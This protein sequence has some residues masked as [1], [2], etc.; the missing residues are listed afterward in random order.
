MKFPKK[1]TKNI[2]Q[3]GP[4]SFHVS[5]MHK[6]IRKTGTFETRKLAEQGKVLLEADAI[7]EYEEKLKNPDI[8]GEKSTSINRNMSTWSFEDT[9]KKACGL[10]QPQGYQGSSDFVTIEGRFKCI[11]SF[12]VAEEVESISDID[13]ELINKYV[14]HALKK[15]SNG[16]VN[17]KL[18]VIR[19]VLGIAKSYKEIKELP[20]F[21]PALIEGSVP[22]R[23]YTSQEINKLYDGFE[24]LIS[25]SQTDVIRERREKVYDCIRCLSDTVARVSEII[26]IDAPDIDFEDRTIRL[27]GKER[28]GTKNRTIRFV[29][30]TDEVYQILWERSQGGALKPF[31]G[32]SRYTVYKITKSAQSIAGFSEDE[33]GA[34]HTL[35][36]TGCSD[37]ANSDYPLP[38]L[39]KL[40]G[41]K[42]ITTTMRYVKV[43]D[44]KD[45]VDKLK[46]IRNRT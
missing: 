10:P 2:T 41:H 7:R 6:G 13:L 24:A 39:Q 14:K 9:F 19:K 23:I 38:K 31:E 3:R 40:A 28:R 20:D 8:G 36:H 4:D 5:L 22:E 26:A 18:S 44:I 30:M 16:T 11:N 12:F 32:I 21:P 27:C 25:Q 33:E 15:N 1:I 45:S 42:H 17:R 43:K 46:N 29:P 37:L 34:V 35:R